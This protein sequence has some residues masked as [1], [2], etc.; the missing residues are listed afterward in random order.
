MAVTTDCNLKCV[1]CFEDG[2][3]KIKMPNINIDQILKFFT[4]NF[5]LE[6]FT[7]ASITLY[8]GEP[9][10]ETDLLLKLSESLKKLFEKYGVK[11]D[12]FLITNG[13]F[14]SEYAISKLV[15]SGLRGVQVTIDGPREIHNQRRMYSN[16]VGTFDDIIKNIHELQ[17]IVPATSIRI[18]IDKS[19]NYKRKVK[20][21]IEFLKNEIDM[22][23]VMI[24]LAPI[25]NTLSNDFTKKNHF[26]F[27]EA[28]TILN[29]YYDYLLEIK[30]NTLDETSLCPCIAHNANGVVINSDGK[31]YNCISL[32][33]REKFEVGDIFK[34]FKPA[35]TKLLNIN[36]WKECLKE[37]CPF[38]PLCV[39]GC[40]FDSVVNHKDIM[41]RY[42]KSKIV[43]SQWLHILKRNLEIKYGFIC[44]RSLDKKNVKEILIDG[45]LI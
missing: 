38:V 2:I 5:K 41:K 42:C 7:T 34:G 8:G 13:T 9:M 26:T 27:N 19:N 32:I 29:E 18:S 1:Y 6:T 3:K 11:L 16:G 14:F 15:S 23:N 20:N 43:S 24:Y 36:K 30:I 21:L 28:G 45:G 4:E 35:Y 37:A 12:L 33:G 22:S 10:V 40:H 17:K 31:L 44:L 25:V 39:G